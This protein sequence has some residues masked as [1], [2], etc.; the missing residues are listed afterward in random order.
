MTPSEVIDIY[1]TD[2]ARNLPRKKQ[3]DVAI[4]LREL[5]T[6]SL[7]ARAEE[8]DRPVDEALTLDMLRQFGRP[9]DVA[10]RYH[11]PFTIIEPADTRNFVIAAFVGVVAIALLSLPKAVAD[12]TH[13]NEV[14]ALCWLGVLVIWFAIKGWRDRHG[15][16]PAW[17]PHRSR[18]AGDND[19]AN[20]FGSLMTI[21]L[22]LG[23]L[24]VYLD[25]RLVAVTGLASRMGPAFFTYAPGF[26]DPWRV[27]L[28]SV[29]FGAYAALYGVVLIE[30]RWRTWS[31]WADWI[32]MFH[33]AVQL[34]W[35][36]NSGPI[37]ILPVADRTYAAFYGIFSLSL[38]I[39]IG[40]KIYQEWERVRFPL[41]GRLPGSAAASPDGDHA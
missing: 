28:V 6:E 7:H 12:G 5:L 25:P 33:I 8:A 32:L 39:T 31:R 23:S 24:A 37:S 22:T 29:I 20:R 17:K 18:N 26:L 41:T 40:A 35:R 10:T 27:A 34:S 19:R 38:L 21:F 13:R 2:V 36:V 11:S 14:A 16:A 4:E 1:V 9:S 15:K 3:S 30:G